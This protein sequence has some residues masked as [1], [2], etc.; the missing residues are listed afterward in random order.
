ML[1]I[2]HPIRANKDLEWSFAVRTFWWGVWL[3]LPFHTFSPLFDRAAGIFPE[4]WWGAIF[5]ASG[6]AHLAALWVNGMCWFTPRIRIA[7]LGCS[8]VSYGGL[9]I[10]VAHVNPFSLG[11][12]LI[13]AMAVEALV[14]TFRAAVDDVHARRKRDAT[15]GT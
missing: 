14:G 6:I 11:F 8:L 12:A 15:N 5:A 10:G 13:L 9:G 2:R 4:A 7:A 1:A 3:L